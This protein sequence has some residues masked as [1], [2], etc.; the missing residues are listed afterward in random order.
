MG[1]T[2]DFL[3]AKGFEADSASIILANIPTYKDHV[4]C[5]HCFTNGFHPIV[6][7]TEEEIRDYK[8]ANIKL[9]ISPRNLTTITTSNSSDGIAYGGRQ[10]HTPLKIGDTFE[11]LKRKMIPFAVNNHKTTT[12]NN[13]NDQY[14]DKEN[15]KHYENSPGIRISPRVP[16]PYT[17]SSSSSSMLPSSSATVAYSSSSNNNFNASSSQ[18]IAMC[19]PDD[20]ASSSQRNVLMMGE[21]G[22]NGSLQAS[23]MNASGPGTNS[24]TTSTGTLRYDN[25]FLL[26]FVV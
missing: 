20:T 3:A 15:L 19:S 22:T 9:T 13:N 25:F 18:G 24:S 6:V 7:N 8:G 26:S 17:S 2:K 11:D 5:P 10:S 16:S 21:L 4:P 14:Q 12:A 23:Y 1:C